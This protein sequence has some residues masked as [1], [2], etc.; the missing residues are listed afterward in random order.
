VKLLATIFF[1]SPY[2]VGTFAR[3]DSEGFAMARNIFGKEPLGAEVYEFVLYYI[4]KL[5]FGKPRQFELE[6]KRMNPKRKQR[7]VR[8]EM[9]KFKLTA[10]PSTFAQ[11]YV[12][13][14]LEQNKKERKR[15]SKNEKEARL[16]GRFMVKQAKKKERRR[17]H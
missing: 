4:D 8:R 15:I 9:E 17:G 10:R 11:N 16:E 6:I 13:E 12:R 1:E 5:N 14:E 7:E 2:W 3:I